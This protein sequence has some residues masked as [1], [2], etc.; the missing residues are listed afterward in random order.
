MGFY[1]RY[2]DNAQHEKI[3]GESTPNYL[4]VSG[5]YPEWVNKGGSIA[6]NIQIPERI[7]NDLGSGV[8]MVVLLR[9]PVHRAV[10]AYLHH[11]K[12]EGRIDL[13][14]DFEENI[15]NYGIAHM[16]FYAA[17]LEAYN[18]LFSAKNIKV[19]IYE[20][21]FA[22]PAKVL[23]NILEFLGVDPNFEFEGLNQLIH[24]AKKDV[25]DGEY[26]FMH[27][28]T[29]MKIIG[30]DDKAFLKSLYADDVERLKNILNDPILEW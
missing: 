29:R 23:Y 13:S 2:F 19:I 20:R 25:E 7:L 4:W 5:Q 10:S 1:E 11:L 15:R 12:F 16:G 27:E 6:N 8:K 9:N 3:I 22:N 17:H 14:A 30:L 26:Y 28:G 18:K 24:S 21:M